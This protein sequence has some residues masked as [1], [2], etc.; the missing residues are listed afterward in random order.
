MIIVWLFTLLYAFHFEVYLNNYRYYMRTCHKRVKI[1]RGEITRE[2]YKG[3]QKE[4]T[5][6][7]KWEN[8]SLY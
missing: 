2:N 3:K 6:R 5:T 8:P 7:E 4:K 1:S